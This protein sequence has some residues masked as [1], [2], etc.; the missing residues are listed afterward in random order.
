MLNDQIEN[1]KL[2]SRFNFV[3]SKMLKL[4]FKDFTNTVQLDEIEDFMLEYSFWPAKDWK[5]SIKVL[6][7]RVQKYVN[8][9]DMDDEDRAKVVRLAL[10]YAMQIDDLKSEI[11]KDSKRKLSDLQR[12]F[13]DVNINSTTI[14][15]LSILDR[16]FEPKIDDEVF[17]GKIPLKDLPEFIP[18]YIAADYFSELNEQL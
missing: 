15:E 11:G 13:R 18:R 8:D 17:A 14:R 2:E 1:T 3:T 6:A 4:N 16:K 12:D 7:P 10:A 9:D 5:N